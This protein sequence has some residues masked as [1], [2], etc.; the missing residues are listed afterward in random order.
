MFAK[1]A[2]ANHVIPAVIRCGS[3]LGDCGSWKRN[4]RSQAKAISSRGTSLR[5][6]S[7]ADR[8]E[9]Q[10]SVR[11]GMARTNEDGVAPRRGESF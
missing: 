2:L 7:Y 10:P 6:L 8:A 11:L 3:N 5:R 4:L 9:T 1:T